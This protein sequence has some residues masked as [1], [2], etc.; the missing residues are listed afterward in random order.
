MAKRRTARQSAYGSSRRRSESLVSVVFFGILLAGVG[1]LAAWDDFVATRD[2]QR[3]VDRGD[4]TTAHDARVFVDVRVHG[5]SRSESAVV[6]AAVDYPAGA[7]RSEL[8]HTGIDT[9]GIPHEEWTVVTGGP[10]SGTFD[11]LY[12]PRDPHLVMEGT[13]AVHGARH[14]EDDMRISLWVMGA[15]LLW[16]ALWAT[17]AWRAGQRRGV[18]GR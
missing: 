4:R 7:Q 14:G 1:A 18:A 2:A 11:V 6:E 17:V 12:D 16:S 8:Q 9:A 15:G 5:R 3:L 10:Y 13:D